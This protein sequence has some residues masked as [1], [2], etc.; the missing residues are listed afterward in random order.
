MNDGEEND[1]WHNQSMKRNES[2]MIS[3]S[4]SSFSHGSIKDA[5]MNKSDRNHSYKA[6]EFLPAC[7][8]KKKNCREKKS[9]PEFPSL[10]SMQCEE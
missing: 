6:S 3:D 2:L 10:A 9:C 1:S 5:G 8:S 7:F 4:N